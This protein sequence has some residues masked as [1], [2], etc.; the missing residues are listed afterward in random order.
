[1]KPAAVGAERGAQGFTGSTQRRGGRTFWLQGG[2][3]GLLPPLLESGRGI[4]GSE[5]IIFGTGCL[6]LLG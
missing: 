1:M 6:G 5:D 4:G 3:R 2:D